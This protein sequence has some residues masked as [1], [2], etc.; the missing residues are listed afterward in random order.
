MQKLLFY[1]DIFAFQSG[2]FILAQSTPQGQFCRKRVIPLI[3]WWILWKTSASACRK[4]AR[5]PGK[6]RF[7]SGGEGKRE[8]TAA[9]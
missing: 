9:A 3:L 4:P 5:N 7:S 6:N 2:N 1:I 8:I